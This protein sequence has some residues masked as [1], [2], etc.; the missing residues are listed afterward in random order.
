MLWWATTVVIQVLFLFLTFFRPVEWHITFG[1]LPLSPLMTGVLA[2]LT[3]AVFSRTRAPWVFFGVTAAM[4]LFFAYGFEPHVSLVGLW[5]LLVVSGIAMFS[6]IPL[7]WAASAAGGLTLAFTIG[8]MTVRGTTVFHLIPLLMAGAMAIAL[9]AGQMNYARRRLLNSTRQRAVEAEH[10]REAV[11]AQRVAEQRLATARDLHDVVGHE[12]AV[13]SIHARVAANEMGRDPDGAR[14]TL[15][16]IH[17]SVARVIAEIN[18]LLHELRADRVVLAGGSVR[19][20]LHQLTSTLRAGGL[21]VDVHIDDDLPP[22]DPALDAT[23]YLIMEEALV[24]AYKYGARGLAATA[25]VSWDGRLV[26]VSVVNPIASH[27]SGVPHRGLGL[28][29]IQERARGLGGTSAT[30]LEHG[31]FKLQVEIPRVLN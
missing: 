24:N 5:F 4:A 26:T 3:L 18:E 30:T 20:R 13:I 16:L 23:V 31:L 17:E 6:V 12:L 10:T 7:R 8:S 14:R 19:E 15:D 28:I 25:R 22:A 11:A 29:G 27:R 1:W 21:S 2:V 9:F